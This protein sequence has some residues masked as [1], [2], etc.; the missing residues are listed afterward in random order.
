VVPVVAVPVEEVPVAVPVAVP[1][2]R[3]VDV[4]VIAVVAVPVEA[5]EVA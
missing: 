1:E 4:A 2:E 5:S 3:V